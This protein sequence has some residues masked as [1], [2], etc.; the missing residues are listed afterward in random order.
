[1]LIAYSTVEKRRR[2]IYINLL[3]QQALII[4]SIWLSLRRNQLSVSDIQF[5]IIQTRSPVSVY[6]LL[7][8]IPRLFFEMSATTKASTGNDKPPG[9]K[10]DT[11]LERYYSSRTFDWALITR[12]LWGG[13]YG[14]SCLGIN[15]LGTSDK[16]GYALTYQ[17]QPG[18]KLDLENPI[19]IRQSKG[20][21]SSITAWFAL[22]V[23]SLVVYECVISR[24]AEERREVM[25]ELSGKRKK[26]MKAWPISARIRWGFVATWFIVMKFHP[27]LPFVY[28]SIFFL[29]WSM[30]M[31]IWTIEDKFDWTY[32]QVLAI[33]QAVVVVYPCL[34]LLFNSR[35]DIVHLPQRLFFDIL[36]LV[37]EFLERL[38][39]RSRLN[40]EACSS[41]C[42]RCLCSQFYLCF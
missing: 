42:R 29:N 2:S 5:A 21:L 3:S 40:R 22:G 35:N 14:F 28:A 38:S 13:L 41:P 12:Q 8:L 17:S 11:L 32:G 9:S 4:L 26:S 10:S 33:S 23:C 30:D 16:L 24:H 7:L 34:T 37:S 19:S 20:S 15:L 39:A 6:A 27:W 36:W 18:Q 1:M 31:R 25:H